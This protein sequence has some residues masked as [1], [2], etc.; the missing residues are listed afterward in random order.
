MHNEGWSF[1]LYE[2]LSTINLVKKLSFLLQ[3]DVGQIQTQVSVNFIYRRH[4]K[5]ILDGGAKKVFEVARTETCR[6]QT[7]S[8]ARLIFPDF[9]PGASSTELLNLQ[10]LCVLHMD[11]LV[12][13]SKS[14]SGERA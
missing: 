5:E 10:E 13:K 2:I 7:P 4:Q 6:P 8:L 14:V 9:Y 11:M 3:E 1:T 12:L